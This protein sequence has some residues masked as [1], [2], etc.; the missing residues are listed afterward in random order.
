MVLRTAVD[1]ENIRINRILRVILA[2]LAH[3][4]VCGVNNVAV[5]RRT[6]IVQAFLV[7]VRVICCKVSTAHVA[8]R[9]RG[10]VFHIYRILKHVVV[11]TSAH[12][13][14]IARDELFPARM[15]ALNEPW[16][17]RVYRAREHECRARDVLHRNKVVLWKLSL[18]VYEALHLR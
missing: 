12:A 17:G 4:L 7:C 13:L 16:I 9:D 15:G 8:K 2:L 5:V 18:A 6:A 14:I 1:A 11:S 10:P 3:F